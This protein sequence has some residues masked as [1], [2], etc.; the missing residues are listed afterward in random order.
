MYANGGVV[1]SVLLVASA[2]AVCP[3]RVRDSGTGLAAA[4]DCKTKNKD[5]SR[6]QNNRFKCISVKK[7]II[8]LTQVIR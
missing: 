6:D 7:R 1:R 8:Q 2:R 4:G 3:C 5:H